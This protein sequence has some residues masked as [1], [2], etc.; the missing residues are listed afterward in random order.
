M[1]CGCGWNKEQEKKQD[2]FLP[3]PQRLAL[4]WP[5]FSGW[6]LHLKSSNFLLKLSRSSISHYFLLNDGVMTVRLLV[7]FTQIFFFS[8]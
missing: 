3:L 4:F 6:L 7:Q 8:I 5:P 2:P 1:V